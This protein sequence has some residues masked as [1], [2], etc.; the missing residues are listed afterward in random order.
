MTITEPRHANPKLSFVT[1]VHL[2]EMD[3]LRLQAR[4]LAQFLNPDAGHEILLLVNDV[5]EQECIREVSGILHEYGAHQDSVRILTGAEVFKRTTGRW[6]LYLVWDGLHGLFKSIFRNKRRVGW[7]G[8]RGWRMQQ[9]FKMASV[10]QAKGALLVILDSK[11]FFVQPVC[12]SDFVAEDGRGRIALRVPSEKHKTWVTS[13]CD[14]L[15]LQAEPVLARR[16]PYFLTPFVASAELM[17][18]TLEQLEDRHGPVQYCFALNPKTKYATEFMMMVAVAHHLMGGVDRHFIDDKIPSLA[19]NGR[20]DIKVI[21]QL[22]QRALAG[23]VK[24]V[25]VH[26][27]SWAR[28]TKTE[29]DLFSQLVQ[30]CGLLTTEPSDTRFLSDLLSQGGAR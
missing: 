24:V 25:A 30:S 21:H 7:G 11:N 5:Q 26:R 28:F 15:N 2:G 4:S 18:R 12:A 1:V 14:A 10:R 20:T 29:A 17:N 23:D 19:T 13:S 3:S 9:A 16:I 22:L 8:Y 27:R 6:R